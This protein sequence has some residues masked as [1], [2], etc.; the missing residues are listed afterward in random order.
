MLPFEEVK[1]EAEPLTENQ[2]WGTGPPARV[3]NAHIRVEPDMLLETAA[4]PANTDD[5]TAD[6]IPD[7]EWCFGCGGTVSH[8]VCPRPALVQQ[9]MQDAVTGWNRRLDGRA[10]RAESAATAYALSLGRAE[11]RIEVLEAALRYCWDA[12]N[13]QL[14]SGSVGDSAE[15]TRCS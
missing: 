6:T 7:V 10:E 5:R 15:S 14:I 4:R 12:L 9:E 2:V 3:D 11:T 13:L 8:C 1:R